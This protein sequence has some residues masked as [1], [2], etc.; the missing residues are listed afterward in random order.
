MN[1]L[2]RVAL[3]LA[4]SAPLAALACTGKLITMVVAFPSGGPTDLVARVLAQKMGEQMGQTLWLITA[5][6]PTGT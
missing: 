1:T 5:Q 4:L 2:Y 3:G 6:A